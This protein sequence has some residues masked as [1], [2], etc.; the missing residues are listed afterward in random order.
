[1]PAVDSSAQSLPECCPPLVD[2][3]WRHD[4]C[5]QSFLESWNFSQA[6][7]QRDGRY[8]DPYGWQFAQDE[9]RLG[10]VKHDVLNFL[11][12]T[13][14]RGTADGSWQMTE[15]YSWLKYSTLVQPDVL[16]SLTGN[17][18]GGFWSGPGA[19][20]LPGQMGRLSLDME[21][22]LL[23]RGPIN[24]AIGFHPQVVADDQ[25]HFTDKALNFDGRVINTHRVSPDWTL[26]YGIGFWDRVDLFVI[27]QVGAVWTPNDRWEL[28]LLFPRSQFSYRLGDVGGGQMWLN[29]VVEYT[30]QAYQVGIESQGRIDRIQL[31]DWRFSTGLRQD[32]YDSSWTADVGIVMD[33]HVTF[34][35]PTPGFDLA[36]TAMFRVGFW[37]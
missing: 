28:R 35:G 30:V 8:F 33:R 11:P 22:V 7:A 16:V 18:D 1:M 36:P 23:G 19:P 4:P 21:A 5:S 6:P 31:Q 27:P 15:F 29:S 14:T 17:A 12:Q 34:Q 10:L 2:D 9:F 32:F 13:S 25:Y 20:S 24:T 3:C 26:V 37:F